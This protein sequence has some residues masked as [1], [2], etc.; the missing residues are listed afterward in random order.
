MVHHRGCRSQ[1]ANFEK[2]LSI[3]VHQSRLW[4][5][6]DADQLRRTEE[7]ALPMVLWRHSNSQETLGSSHALGALG[8]PAEQAE[9]CPTLLLSGWRPGLVLRCV[10][11]FVRLLPGSGCG[12]QSLFQPG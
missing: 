11:S 6:I 5:W 3:F 1:P 7:A 8:G 10:Q 12:L 4:Q 2:G 9:P